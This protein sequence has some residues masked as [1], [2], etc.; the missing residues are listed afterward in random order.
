M[1]T[2]VLIRVMR[3]EDLAFAAECTAAEGWLS[4][5]LTTLEGFYLRDPTGCLLAEREG[6]PVGMCVATFYGK[7]GFIG[8]LIVRPEARGYGI[9]AAL[10]NH[11]VRWLKK[12]GSETVYLDGVLKA[13]DLYERNGFRK[14]CR[15]WRFSNQLT[16]EQS[17][18]VRRMTERD[19]P[20]VFA[21]DRASFGAERSFFLRRRLELFPELCQVMVAG[22]RLIGYIQGRRSE[23]WASAGPWVATEEATEP[24]L[25]LK[26]FANEVGDVSIS[27]GILDVNHRAVELVRSLGF[28]ENPDSPWRMALGRSGD[29]GASPRCYAVGSAAKG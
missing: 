14:I 11:G 16:G 27:T 6:Q 12:R 2:D 18:Q 20:E 22:G 26:A 8:E 7:S 19:L 23:G 3:Q 25:L 13:V 5:N 29:L 10:V 28:V 17:S 24:E 1:L 4:E 9:G 21:L 15:S